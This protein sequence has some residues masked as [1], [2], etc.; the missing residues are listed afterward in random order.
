MEQPQIESNNQIPGRAALLL[1][2]K[3]P[4]F[5]SIRRSAGRW[6]VASGYIY[7]NEIKLHKLP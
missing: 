2:Q 4:V 7:I 6:R 3:V 1:L 5:E